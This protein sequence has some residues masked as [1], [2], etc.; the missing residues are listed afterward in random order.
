MNA[1]ISFF[2]G[3]TPAGSQLDSLNQWVAE[4]AALT[5]PDHIHWCDGSDAEY[6]ALVQQM[7]A[8]GTCCR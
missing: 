2:D 8:D 1:A 7:Q 6:A 4:I 5:Q 3:K